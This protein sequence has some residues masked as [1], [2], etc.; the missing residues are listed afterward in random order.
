M[1]EDEQ[2]RAGRILERQ[3]TLE[4]RLRADRAQAAAALAGLR[5]TGRPN[6]WVSTSAPVYVDRSA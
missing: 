5:G 6:R 3:R 2:S 1:R 4:D